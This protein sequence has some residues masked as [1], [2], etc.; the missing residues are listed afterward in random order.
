MRRFNSNKKR[1]LRELLNEYQPRPF[2]SIRG[3]NSIFGT[4]TN[5][6]YNILDDLVGVV[7]LPV[8]NAGE[9]TLATDPNMLRIREYLYAN[10]GRT[11]RITYLVDGMDITNGR[12]QVVDFTLSIPNDNDTFENFWYGAKWSFAGEDN[13]GSSVFEDNNYAGKIYIRPQQ[14][15]ATT[16]RIKQSFL[17]GLMHCVF[18]PILNWAKECLSKAGSESA[19]KRYNSKINKIAKYSK[20]YDSGVPE[21]DIEPLCKDLNIKINIS[22][23]F[24][25]DESKY[26]ERLKNADKVFNFINTRLN[27]LEIGNFVINKKPES[28][29]RD[30]IYSEIDRLDALNEFYYTTK[31]NRGYNAVYT[32]TDC[33]SCSTDFKET[34]DKFEEQNGMKN[35]RICD[36]KHSELASFIKRGTHYNT[37]I[38][39]GS[40][41]DV[42][43]NDNK[44]V[45][46]IDQ[47][48]AYYHFKKCKFYQGFLGKITD[49]RA[50]DKVQGVGLYLITKLY[51]G[52][53]SKRVFKLLEKMNWFVNGNV[54]TSAELKLLDSLKIDYKIISGCWG[55]EPFH[56]E[57]GNEFLQKTD[58]KPFVD[59]NGD[60][61]MKGISYYAKATGAWDS[62]NTHSYRYIK[63][64][65]EYAQVLK[66]TSQNTIVK[67][68][69]DNEICV[70][71]PKK[72][73]STLGHI[74]AFILAYQRMSLLDQ[75]LEMDIDKLIGV[76]VDGIYYK[77][78]A[79]NQLDTFET[80]EIDSTVHLSD[81]TFLSNIFQTKP[82]IDYPKSRETYKTELFIG[83][84][85][86]GKTHFNLTDFGLVNLLYVA[87]SH[88]LNANKKNEYGVAVEVLASLLTDN[89]ENYKRIM[90]Y[91]NI[92][93]DEVSMMGNEEKIKLMQKFPS[94]KL[95]FCGDVGFQLPCIS[96]MEEPKTPFKIEGF[97]KI[98]EFTTNYRCKD[99]TLLERLNSLRDCIKDK[100]QVVPN[101]FKFS[102]QIV[103]M[104]YVKNNYS[105]EDMIISGTNKAKDQYTALFPDKKKWYVTK[106]TEYYNNGDIVIQDEQP[107]K[108]AVIRH[109]YTS[110]SIQGETAENKLFIDCATLKDIKAFY[111]AVSRARQMKQIFMVVRTITQ[112]E[113][114]E[115]EISLVEKKEKKSTG[116]CNDCGASCGKYFRCMN[117]HFA[118]KGVDAFHFDEIPF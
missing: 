88:K 49:F 87:P 34:L 15:L 90:R 13:S 2:R 104:D 43:E 96:T 21:E 61:C 98:T 95:I 39:F 40:F 63:G 101:D 110:H 37:S 47:K 42:T 69:D 70:G 20:K 73:I 45:K 66:N 38:N 35:M 53:C 8:Q 9:A 105:V 4:N 117:C 97:D 112:A 28:V 58:K 19:K 23:P 17:D 114:N 102:F 109:A 5:E 108:H 83:A 71:I 26:G 16:D 76:Y 68:N 24:S 84:G 92:L 1:V 56:F 55:I 64:N 74:T 29:T 50:T 27:H 116:V 44:F 54:Y 89:P 52:R 10:R 59:E 100:Q 25:N 78:H 85:G 93:F 51:F 80:K 60:L 12:N 65:N 32:L 62:H 103:D 82:K 91:N 113:I 118:F 75:L 48:K 107:D 86:N 22:Y 3:F 11:V 81:K 99:E 33:Y 115:K 77:E 111:T 31:D 94:H 18:T 14:S 46:L 41:G 67:F 72:S 57:F 106:N 30:F 6:T 7:V 36:I 79:F